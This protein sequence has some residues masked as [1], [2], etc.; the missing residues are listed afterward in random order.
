MQIVTF[1]S[2]LVTPIAKRFEVWVPDM[3]DRYLL[4]KSG[5]CAESND[6]EQRYVDTAYARGQGAIGETWLSGRPLV[7]ENNHAIG[8]RTAYLPFILEGKLHSIV[9]LVF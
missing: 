3:E 6:L 1:L 4:F 7:E 8:E 2:T 9:C 5:F